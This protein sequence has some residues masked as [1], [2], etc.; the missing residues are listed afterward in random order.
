MLHR[1][2]FIILCAVAPAMFAQQPATQSQPAAAKPAASS[3]SQVPEGGVPSFVRPETPE[4]R[5]T[6]LGTTDDPGINPD[7]KAH[8]FRYGHSF[9][10]SRFDRQWAKYDAPEGWVR[11]FA[12]ANVSYEIYQQNDKY[13]WTWVKDEDPVVPATTAPNGQTPEQSGRYNKNALDFLKRERPLFTSLPIGNVA[14]TVQFK[15]ASNGLPPKGSYRNSLE[16][17]DM[18]GDGC[19][20]LITPPERKGNGMPQIFLGDCKG[21]WKPWFVRF[22]H[23]VDYGSVAAADFNKDGKMD[24]AFA[25]HLIGVY[26]F[27]GDGKGNFTDASEGLPQN[28]PTRRI[29]VADLDGDGYPDLVIPNEGPTQVGR[30]PAQGAVL[31]L[32]NR[33]KG[34]KWESVVI[35]P[36]DVQV[37]GDWISVGNFNGDRYPDMFVA[38]AYYSSTEELQ[39][40][41]GPNK[42]TRFASNGNDIPSLAYYF[43]SAAGKFTGGKRDDVVVSYVRYW[44]TD[45]N[46]KVV[47]APDLREVTN[48]DLVSFQNDKLVRTPLMRWEGH[49]GVWGMGAGDFDGDGNLDVLMVR[50]D[51]RSATLLLG[52]GKGGFRAANLDGLD[53]EP[54]R[55]YDVK[56]ADVNKDGRPDVILM[57]ETAASTNVAEREGSIHV[58]LNKGP[59]AGSPG[60][61]KVQTTR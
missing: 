9:H 17:A 12:F 50:E 15:E 48:V 20:D 21:N 10:I 6:R 61:E 49:S 32:L 55:L 2:L 33:N 18:N 16:V 7:P 51:P 54:N 13:V 47:P 28:F 1:K 53:L 3:T 40:S 19:P 56:V 29:A 45:V 26:V 58:F 24:L 25:V 43:A 44:P 52:D 57:Y 38:S 14:R 11:P 30:P 42:W 23:T 59:V 39:L 4:Q 41:D 22:P 46:P 5:K 35:A 36:A 60:A 34:T 27:L 8:F 37:G 31:G